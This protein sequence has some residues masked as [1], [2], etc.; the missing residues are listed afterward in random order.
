MSG[1]KRVFVLSSSPDNNEFV[2][3]SDDEDNIP[4]ASVI[5]NSNSK[6]SAEKTLSN[7]K[8]SAEK[9]SRK[10][11]ESNAAQDEESTP[12]KKYSFRKRD[13][14]KIQYYTNTTW[15]NP[16][17]IPDD[18]RLDLDILLEPVEGFDFE[19]K[20]KLKHKD[21]RDDDF[22]PPT[23]PTSP[24][25]RPR[26]YRRLFKRS[27]LSPPPTTP[28]AK[29]KRTWGK[30]PTRLRLSALNSEKNISKSQTREF[31]Y[32]LPSPTL[33]SVEELLRMPNN[34]RDIMRTPKTKHSSTQYTIPRSPPLPSTRP[35]LYSPP[36][37][38]DNPSEFTFSDS[39]L[40]YR[41][42]SFALPPPKKSQSKTRSRHLNF[43][44]FYE[45]Q[46]PELY[47]V[48]QWLR[49]VKRAYKTRERLNLTISDSPWDKIIIEESGK[50][51]ESHLIRFRHHFGPRQFPNGLHINR[52][53]MPKL[54]NSRI[55]PDNRG[56]RNN[57]SNKGVGSGNSRNRVTF[58]NRQTISESPSYLAK[59][60]FKVVPPKISIQTS[61]YKPPAVN[62]SKT[63]SLNIKKFRTSDK[64]MSISST[65]DIIATAIHSNTTTSG[66]GS[67]SINTTANS[68]PN[69]QYTLESNGS[70][71][72]NI[73]NHSANVKHISAENQETVADIS[74]SD[75][76]IV[77]HIKPSNGL[78]SRQNLNT[79]NDTETNNAS[80]PK[81]LMGND[82]FMRESDANKGAEDILAR[83]GFTTSNISTNVGVDTSNLENSLTNRGIN[84]SSNTAL[85]KNSNNI[86]TNNN[87]VGYNSNIPT[88][89][90][91]TAYNPNSTFHN[92]F[93]L[94]TR[95]DNLFTPAITSIS[96]ST[97]HQNQTFSTP[98]NP[99]EFND[100]ESDPVPE[101]SLIERKSWLNKFSQK[102]WKIH[103]PEQPKLPKLKRVEAMAID[104]VQ[105]IQKFEDSAVRKNNIFNFNLEFESDN[106]D[107][108]EEVIEDVILPRD[109]ITGG[110]GIQFEYSRPVKS[111]GTNLLVE[112]LEISSDNES[113][114]DNDNDDDDHWT[115][116]TSTQS[117]S[118]LSR[119]L[120][121]RS[122]SNSPLQS[123]IKDFDLSRELY[124][125]HVEAEPKVIDI[126]NF[127]FNELDSL[128]DDE[129]ELMS[130]T[131]TD[132]N[133]EDTELDYVT[134]GDLND[135]D[136]DDLNISNANTNDN[137]TI[138]F[139]GSDYKL[140][141]PK[142]I[143][144]LIDLATSTLIQT[145]FKINQ[146]S[147]INP[148]N[149]KFIFDYLNLIEKDKLEGYF[150]D[151]KGYVLES[152]MSLLNNLNTL[153]NNLINRNN[154]NRANYLNLV[155]DLYL[156][157]LQIVKSLNSLDYS[158]RLKNFCKILLKFELNE[159]LQ[160][161]EIR[162]L[163]SRNNIL[164]KVWIKLSKLCNH[165]DNNSWLTNNWSL[166][167]EFIADCYDE[168]SG[169][170]K[171]IMEYG[172]GS[173]NGLPSWANTHWS[174]EFGMTIL[175]RSLLPFS[176]TPNINEIEGIDHWL[177]FCIGVK[178]TN[179]K[180]T[181]KLPEKV[182][183]L[184]K[185]GD[186]TNYFIHWQDRVEVFINQLGWKP[187]ESF[188]ISL[189]Q[190][191]KERNYI[192]LA[193]HYEVSNFQYI[194]EFYTCTSFLSTRS[195]DYFTLLNWY[196]A[197]LTKNTD[198]LTNRSLLIF[199]S[200]V[201]PTQPLKLKSTHPSSNYQSFINRVSLLI[202]L[203]LACS[204]GLINLGTLLKRLKVVIVPEWE[205]FDAKTLYIIGVSYIDLIGIRMVKFSDE[206][207]ELDSFRYIQKVISQ[208]HLNQ[209]NLDNG[210]GSSNNSSL[211][212]Q[213]PLAELSENFQILI[214]LYSKLSQLVSSL[215]TCT[216]PGNS[217]Q[218]KLSTFTQFLDSIKVKNMIS[219]LTRLPHQLRFFYLSLFKNLLQKLDTSSE[220]G[221]TPQCTHHS[222]A[223]SLI[224]NFIKE[225]NWRNQLRFL[226]THLEL[227]LGEE[228]EDEENDSVDD[229]D[230]KINL[231]EFN[232]VI[233][234]FLELLNE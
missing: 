81:N 13:P 98:L 11:P 178:S 67:I 145:L 26:K 96:S 62:K 22:V 233:V 155:F 217:D 174:R 33:P 183:D 215:N 173:S 195:S 165:N 28:Q 53:K 7:K 225:D 149:V 194:K 220:S 182:K 36:N 47:Y 140:K 199:L 232:R 79:D 39:E 94:P 121:L 10:N 158:T 108:V 45:S 177:Q 175:E 4:I 1:K 188:L 70:S 29:Q 118:R 227:D 211:L 191:Y 151:K 15:V 180:L 170:L 3:N 230:G 61:M 63:D 164:E 130:E 83:L 190:F 228:A 86:Q 91:Y 17:T 131:W 37:T 64:S 99:I 123:P 153:L 231:G 51:N 58:S 169:K 115:N 27:L 90:N 212:E 35:L 72:S 179:A 54:R 218:C 184:V 167:Y 30:N 2:L 166:Y 40:D 150:R 68:I 8:K 226:K 160:S 89:S 207:I 107:E 87:N 139:M 141:I 208:L 189:L 38:F 185:I 142:H 88:H 152:F 216:Q 176:K 77:N 69:N 214:K 25:S 110:D 71:T 148:S 186:D 161:W 42:P 157:I 202:T 120:V 209:A 97:N 18:P 136:G 43:F 137:E 93:P 119:S 80:S 9:K 159:I 73:Q 205:M 162:R 132:N 198:S 200:K 6:K 143:T 41:L 187:S 229:D 82:N 196:K 105:N 31:D 146:N 46:L 156:K 23:L 135:F 223:K 57:S 55:T 109:G 95:N 144:N 34:S 12:R 197:Y 106:E 138:Y 224:L 206:Y 5:N 117:R 14:Q 74:S 126:N 52:F 59:S 49:L 122:S 32:D 75:G 100:V 128:G 204:T 163:Q 181:D 129:F 102:L 113:N 65:S 103:H 193:P 111:S 124:S 154:A 116:D 171:V 221:S 16:S 20:T 76:I 172:N 203:G 101:K 66:I 192:Q 133:D 234:Y 168:V 112:P 92:P 48:P 21:Q 125:D 213:K 50:T 60:M 84:S 134:H 147:T 19:A 219:P 127:N 104:S 44:K 210:S 78:R 201:F 114:K 85:F 56:N 222:Q 24:N